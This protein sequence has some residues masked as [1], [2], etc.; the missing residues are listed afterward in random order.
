MSISNFREIVI[1]KT[2]YNNDNWCQNSFSFPRKTKLNTLLMRLN[3]IFELISYKSKIYFDIKI[4]L[5]IN[6]VYIINT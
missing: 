6:Y 4:I 1:C 2:L 5:I 3:E